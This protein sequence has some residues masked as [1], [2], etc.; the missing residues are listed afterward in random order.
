MAMTAAMVL[1]FILQ[2]SG[3]GYTDYYKIEV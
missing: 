2:F 3:A 1:F